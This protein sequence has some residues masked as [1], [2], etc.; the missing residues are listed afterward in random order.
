MTKYILVG[1]YLH[2]AEDGGRAFLKELVEGFEQDKPVRILNCL[3]AQ[4]KDT[5]VDKLQEN[6][7]FFSRYLNN[8]EFILADQKQFVEQVKAADVIFLQGGHTKPL[9]KI[10]SESGNW[11]K[12]LAGKTIAG[13]SAGGEIMAQYYYVGKTKRI[14]VGF[15]LLPIKFIPHWH[16]NLNECKNVDWDQ[17]W[18]ELKDY[19]EDLPICALAEGEF[20]IFN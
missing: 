8:F 9:I 4:P 15:G 6:K 16:S 3:F 20:K 17:A 19:R 12:E 5:W 7:K 1:G 13:T 11:I 10:L 14:G 18:Q 2:K